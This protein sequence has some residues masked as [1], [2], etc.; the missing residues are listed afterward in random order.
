[1]FG[2]V[3]VLNPGSSAT[4]LYLPV[5]SD[6]AVYSPALS[7]T[8]VRVN[9]VPRLVSVTVAPE[10][11]APVLSVMVPSTVPVTACAATSRGNRLATTR[12]PR[13]TLFTFVL[14]APVERRDTT[15]AILNPKQ[16]PAHSRLRA[17]RRRSSRPSRCR[18]ACAASGS[19]DRR[20]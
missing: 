15:P 20:R 6:G 14:H 4:S 17:R 13:T 11:A 3:H 19:P 8:S 2:S 12:R 16:L 9:P 1:M 7:V 10:T 5:G 18:P